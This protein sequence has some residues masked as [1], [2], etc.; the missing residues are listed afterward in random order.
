M[1]ITNSHLAWFRLK[2]PYQRDSHL[3]K[4]AYAKL[5][6]AT[7]ADIEKL[8]AE[9]DEYDD[10]SIPVRH[11]KHKGQ[12]YAK[13]VSGGTAQKLNMKGIQQ[14]GRKWRVQKRSAGQLRRW[15]FD[16][17]EEAQTKRDKVFG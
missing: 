17:F 15:T 3:Y 8:R 2:C 13:P 5:K 7:Y 11:Y 12:W 1:S 14:H 9:F 16:T 10:G 6:N 4:Q